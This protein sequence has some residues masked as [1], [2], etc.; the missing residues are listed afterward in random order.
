MKKLI[1]TTFI[2][3]AL[4]VCGYAQTSTKADAALEAAMQKFINSIETKNTIVFL[5]FVSPAKGITVM[6]TIDQG[7]A[8]N[9][10]KPML[11]SK[12][13]Y[14]MLAADFKKK[15][16]FY[17]DIFLPSEFSPNFY[18]AFANR[19][20]KWL[21][22]AGN[23]FRIVDAETGTPSNMLYV[24]WEKEENRWTVVEIGRPIS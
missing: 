12:L 8:G 23:K 1:T 7:D 13:A 14:K 2:L 20:E 22:G 15:G 3:F 24:R 11:D 6:N 4:T 10:E 17:Q 21:L 18:E 9:A 5:S 19:K 16:E